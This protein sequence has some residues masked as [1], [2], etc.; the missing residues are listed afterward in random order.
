MHS[1]SEYCNTINEPFLAGFFEEDRSQFYRYCKA[2]ARFFECRPLPDYLGGNLYPSGPKHAKDQYAVI[3]DYSY[4]VHI[5]TELEKKS[6]KSFL[7]F[8]S[9]ELKML[10]YPKTVHTVGGYRYTHSFP[11]YERVER[12][13]L[14]SYRERIEKIKD[15]DFREGLLAL[16]EG[17]KSYHGRVVKRLQQENAPEQLVQ[18]LMTVPFRPAKTLYE[19][20]VCRNFV[21]YLDLC[22][23]LGRLDQELI[24]FY[25]GEDVTE[26]FQELF[27]NV[28]VNDGWSSAI[29]PEY[30][31]LT[32]QVL[33]ASRGQRRPSIELRVTENMPE[34]IWKEAV[35]SIQSGS[36]QPCFYNEALYQKSLAKRFPHI[37]SSDLM[38]FNGGGCTE[39]MLAGISRVGSLDAGI[40]LAYILRNV[41]TMFL[42]LAESFEDFYEFFCEEVRKATE[43]TLD[44]VLYLYKQQIDYVPQP[45]RTLLVDDCIDNEK[46]FNAG[47]AR[48]NWS[49]INFAG[50]INVIDSL[51]AIR[52]LI[53]VKRIYTAKEFEELLEKEDPFFFAQLRACPCFGVDDPVADEFA[54]KVAKRVFGTL[55]GKREFYLEGFLPASIQFIT[56]IDAGKYVGATPDGRHAGAPLCD[57]LAPVHGKDIKGVTAMLNSVTRIELSQALG[58]PVLN[59]SLRPQYVEKLLKPIVQGFFE[60]GGMQM[61]ITCVSKED[62]LDAMEH[63]LKHENLIVRVGGYSEYFHRLSKEMQ[64]SVVMRTMYE[65]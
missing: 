33:R 3:P 44:K 1:I 40:N 4:S 52:E 2:Y 58:T 16:W 25:K 22:D 63:P 29:G 10:N 53:F 55:D 48:Y 47:G 34:E 32:I 26:L 24:R 38:R 6:S 28:D 45:M 36:G 41:M 8:V 5:T 42:P 60:K 56:Y 19:A 59:V 65:V 43:D 15:K 17:I 64:R 21:F 18:A 62:L 39:T 20:I 23:E 50:L 13:G 37:P 12:E 57:S 14:D 49:V 35:A 30:N 27:Q 46:D 51:L 7:D 11:N 9:R 31:E 54:A 61:Q